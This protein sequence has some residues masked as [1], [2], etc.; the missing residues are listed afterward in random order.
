MLEIGSV[1]DGKY[2]IL[3]EI[4]HGGMSNVYLAINERANKQW[5][6]KEVRKDGG[7]NK[8]IIRQNLIAETNILKKLRHPNLPS[9]VDIIKTDDYFLICMDYIEGITLLKKLE[10]EGAQPQDDVVK[11]A[12]QIC[13][14]LKYLHSQTP[15]IIYRDTKP[16]NIMLKPNGDV[17][18][19]DFGTAREY[20]ETKEEDT[21]WLG[22]RGYAAPEQ[23]GG[24]GQTDERTDIFNLGATMYHLVTGHNPSKPPYEMYPIRKWDTNLSSGLEDIILKCTKKNPEERY[25]NCDELLYDL[26]HYHELEYGYIR[27]QMKHKG[28]VIVSAFLSVACFISSFVVSATATNMTID[29]YAAY[30]KEAQ[31]ATTEEDRLNAYKKAIS[32]NPQNEQAYEEILENML[33]DGNF[34]KSDAEEMTKILGNIPEGQKSPAEQSLRKNSNGYENFAYRLG[35][36]YFYYYNREGNKQM[37]QPW[38]GVAK[39]GNLDEQK[40]IRAERFYRISDYYS[41]LSNRDRAGDSEISYKQYWEDLSALTQGNL[42]REDNEQTAIVMYRELLYQIQMHANEFR[43]S[44]VS[45]DVIAE[46]IKQ[47]KNHLASDFNLEKLDDEDRENI[48]N[49]L[50]LSDNAS[51]ALDSAFAK[52]KGDKEA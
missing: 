8:E 2:K 42:V 38:F 37:S 14:V 17:V 16:A 21:Q 30:I 26:E 35:I 48:E 11:W 19:I 10:E 43:K 45:R 3:H 52:S 50:I 41:A 13:N 6:I 46:K 24:N 7:P 23:F 18:L 51:N 32:V 33:D 49:L 1:I 4:G 22:T 31:T 25:Q 40:K 15:K 34:S 12:I 27:Q 36:A 28:R 5:A 44:G 20:R 9:I 39:D 47:V 29:H